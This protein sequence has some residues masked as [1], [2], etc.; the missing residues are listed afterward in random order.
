VLSV[1][2]EAALDQLDAG[3]VAATVVGGQIAYAVE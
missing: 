2:P 1:A 3:M